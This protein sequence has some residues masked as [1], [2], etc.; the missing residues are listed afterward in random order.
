[1]WQ[2]QELA[3]EVRAVEVRY[4]IPAGLLAAIVLAEA[5]GTRNII[6]RRRY[7]GGRDYGAGQV[8]ALN[9]SRRRLALLLTLSTNLDRAGQLL[10]SS[11][12]R[13]ARHPRWA[14]CR[15]GEFALYNAGSRTWAGRVRRIWTRL[16][17]RVAGRGGES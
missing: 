16:L 3:E 8:H 5:G 10:A 17:E 15:R 12:S 14:A 1:M 13:C 11:R 9:P 7:N 4:G 6:S 2:A